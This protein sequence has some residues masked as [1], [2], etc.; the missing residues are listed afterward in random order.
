MRIY[1]V[2]L[3]PTICSFGCLYDVDV[4]NW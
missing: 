1:D 4:L 2:H 3:L